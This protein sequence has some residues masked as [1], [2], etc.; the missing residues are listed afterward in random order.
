MSN[1]HIY[2]C[3]VLLWVIYHIIYIMLFGLK[4]PTTIGG[5]IQ[6]LVVDKIIYFFL[7]IIIEPTLIIKLWNKISK[8]Y[9]KVYKRDNTMW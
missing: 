7:I 2:K 9:D 6:R 8:L 1:E 3:N 4:K 5:Y